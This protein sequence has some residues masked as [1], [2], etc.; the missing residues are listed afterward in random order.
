MSL[1]KDIYALEILMCYT[2]YKAGLDE[3]KFCELVAEY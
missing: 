3:F 2:N 1:P